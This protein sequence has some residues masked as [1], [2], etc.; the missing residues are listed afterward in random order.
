MP[1]FVRRADRDGAALVLDKIHARFPWA[2]APVKL[3]LRARSAALKTVHTWVPSGRISNLLKITFNLILIFLSQK[4]LTI[5]LALFATKLRSH[6][7]LCDRIPPMT[8]Q[9]GG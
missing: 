3:P 8:K 4:R 5:V 1:A 9:A 7:F 6:R 2:A